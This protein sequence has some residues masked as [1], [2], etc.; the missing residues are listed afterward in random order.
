MKK[1]NDFGRS[2]A[3]C[4][5]KDYLI[6]VWTNV[7]KYTQMNKTQQNKV[8]FLK[9]LNEKFSALNHLRFHAI[10]NKCR[11]DRFSTPFIATLIFNVITTGSIVILKKHLFLSLWSNCLIILSNGPYSQ[12]SLIYISYI[13][14]R[15]RNHFERDNSMKGVCKFCFYGLGNCTV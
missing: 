10:V 12:L 1:E 3:F 7:Y 11:S 6:S 4:Y 15:Q 8:R 9:K 5:R 2:Y 13:F 14:K